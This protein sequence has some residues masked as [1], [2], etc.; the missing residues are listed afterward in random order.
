MVATNS[1]N[2]QGPLPADIASRAIVLGEVAPAAT[3]VKVLEALVPRLH[4]L[5]DETAMSEVEREAFQQVDWLAGRRIKEPVA[6]LARGVDAQGALLVDTGR[7]MQR[8][9]GGGVECS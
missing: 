5:S 8:V 3:R 2:V 7:G 4:Q 1:S 9:V 6:G